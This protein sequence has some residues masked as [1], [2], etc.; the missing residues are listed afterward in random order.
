MLVASGC[1]EAAY[2]S[3][4]TLNYHANGGN[5]TLPAAQTVEEYTVLIVAEKG[6]LT[7]P[8][9]GRLFS[10]WNTRASG[11]G[12][13]Y[14]PGDPILMEFGY[15]L[16]AQWYNALYTVRYDA[17]GGTGTVPTEQTANAGA[18]V[19]VSGQG[20]L[21]YTGKSFIGWNTEDDGSG[22]PYAANA[23]LTVGG[24]LTLYAQWVDQYTVRY[25]A[26]G[27]TGTVPTAQTANT[28]TAVTV[29][30]QGSLSNTGKSFIGWNTEDDGSGTPYAANASLTVGGDLI[31]YAQWTTIHYTITY[32]VNGGTG[33]VPQQSADWG[34]SITL[35]D[36]VTRNGYHF[37]GWRPL[38]T[39]TN[40][41]AGSSFT[42]TGNNAQIS[43]Y[44]Q[45]IAPQIREGDTYKDVTSDGVVRIQLTPGNLFVFA[46]T[47]EYRLY[48]STTQSGPYTVVAT[49]LPDQLVLEDTMADWF[50]SGSYFYKVTSVA[51][52]VEATSIN[53]VRINKVAAE[54]FLRTTF[55]G[56]YAIGFVYGPGLDD[57]YEGAMS[58]A[59]SNATIRITFDGLPPPT[60]VCT[61]YTS[62]TSLFL[63]DRGDLTVRASHT[64]TI[65]GSTGAVE[66]SF[67]KSNW[68]SFTP[69]P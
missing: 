39:G 5:G 25:D 20:S 50:S 42:P 43:L 41:D 21:S 60:G 8:V 19:T 47:E 18:A 4:Y 12:R 37:A 22:T 6:D 52:G 66:S 53:G 24:D 31:L 57:I 51:D 29:S 14:D 17:N 32:N 27:A 45:W 48:R 62:T 38:G 26:N 28:G 59:P 30:G 64:Y 46:G 13:S 68:V 61:L 67:V 36:A 15:T 65:N 2:D 33:T 10:G 7:H 34:D 3:S 56:Y 23:S 9:P 44:A 58:N 16:Y 35:A 1:K 55:S 69:V 54:V 63:Y 11:N 40:Y 49:V